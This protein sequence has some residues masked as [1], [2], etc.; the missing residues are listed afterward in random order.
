MGIVV[1]GSTGPGKTLAFL[2]PLLSILSDSLF[3]HQRLR[4]GTEENVGNTTGDLLERRISVVTSPAPQSNSR[5]PVE[6]ARL[7]RAHLLPL[8]ESPENTSKAR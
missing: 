5:Q 2:V 3:A 7:P 8:W 6:E 4:V 1:S